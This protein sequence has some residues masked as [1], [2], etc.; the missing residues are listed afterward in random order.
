MHA[1]ILALGEICVRA[2]SEGVSE[3][4]LVLSCERLLEVLVNAC[5]PAFL[6]RFNSRTVFSISYVSVH[7]L[8]QDWERFHACM[9][10]HPLPSLMKFLPRKIVLGV[11]V[12]GSHFLFFLFCFLMAYKATKGKQQHILQLN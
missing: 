3:C 8:E 10:Y 5:L 6:E 2:L 1:C 11:M 12:Q 9:F 4:A 7:A